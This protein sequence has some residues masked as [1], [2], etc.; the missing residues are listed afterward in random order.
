MRKPTSIIILFFLISLFIFC[1]QKEPPLQPADYKYEY[2]PLKIGAW[3]VYDVTKR[4]LDTKAGM[5]SLEK[6]QIKEVVESTFTDAEGKASYRIEKY[7]RN[8]TSITWDNATVDNVFF[9]TLTSTTAERIEDNLRFVKLV[10]PALEKRKW[11]GNGYIISQ[12]SSLF[13]YKNWS[14]EYTKIDEMQQVG[15]FVFDSTMTV[16]Q[17]N[18]TTDNLVEARFGLEKYVKHVGLVYKKL[19]HLEYRTQIIIPPIPPWEER[20]TNG[21]TLEIMLN[22]YGEN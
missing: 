21:F 18:D 11:N 15:T 10:F 6:Y 13:F 9:S 5:D 16:N 7:R 17:I 14:Y 2:F 20:A 22:S 1:N 4:V 8:D 12:D 3:A 19:W